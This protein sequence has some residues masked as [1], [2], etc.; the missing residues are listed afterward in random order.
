M[1]DYPMLI[2][3]K[4]HSFR[5]FLIQI[6]S[7][8]NGIP[9]AHHY[10]TGRRLSEAIRQRTSPCE[11]SVEENWKAVGFANTINYVC[12]SALVGKYRQEP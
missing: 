3:N 1:S 10:K 12:R 4:L 9:L 7:K 11:P 6:S 5:N 2:S 8:R